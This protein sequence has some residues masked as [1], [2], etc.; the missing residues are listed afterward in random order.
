MKWQKSSR[1]IDQFNKQNDTWLQND[2]LFKNTKKCKSTEE[3]IFVLEEEHSEEKSS[4]S[5]FRPRMH[6][7]GMSERS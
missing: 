7:S 2:I 5:C 4:S 1:S 3:N 6:F